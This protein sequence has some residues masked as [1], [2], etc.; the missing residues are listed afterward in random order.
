MKQAFHQWICD[1]DE[2]IKREFH[3]NNVQQAWMFGVGVLFIAVS[4][5]L[6]GK[7]GMVWYTVLSTIGAFSMWEAAGIWIIHN[8]KLRMR[9][10]IAKAIGENAEIKIVKNNGAKDS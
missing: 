10:K 8:P 2:G 6:D 3:K 5:L 1:E 4:L 9:K 7:V